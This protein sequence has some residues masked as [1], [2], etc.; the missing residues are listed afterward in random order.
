MNIVHLGLWQLDIEARSLSKGDSQAHLKPRTWDVLLHLVN[1]AGHLVSTEELLDQYWRGAIS[2]ETAV[3]KAISEIRHEIDDPA[4]NPQVIKTVP[5]RGY[6]LALPDEPS[7]PFV[8]GDALAVLPFVNITGDPADEYLCDGLSEE[9]LNAMVQTLDT[10][11]IARTSSFQF[12][13]LNT[14]VK[15]IASRLSANRILEG[16]LRRDGSVVRVTAQLIDGATGSHIWS[17][18]YDRES[19]NVF[20]LQESI[21]TAICAKISAHT[22]VHR[23]SAGLATPNM[24][25]YDLFLRATALGESGNPFEVRD[26]VTLFEQAVERDPAFAAAWLGLAN[27][28]IRLAEDR[29]AIMPASEVYPRAERALKRVLAL[30]PGNSRAI[31]LLGWIS[32]VLSYKWDAGM[33]LMERSLAATPNDAA[34]LFKYAYLRYCM[35]L[36]DGIPL[37]EEACKL[38]PL[39]PEIVYVLAVARLFAGAPNESIQTIGT[40]LENGR[41]DY[42]THFLVAL[43]NAFAGRY[44]V[45][46]AHYTRARKI[47]GND[48][49]AIRVLEYYVAAIRNLPSQ[50]RTTPA[51]LEEIEARSTDEFF[52]MIVT[53]GW[54]ANSAEKMWKHAL[55]QQQPGNLMYLFGDKPVQ[56]SDTFWH[57]VTEDLGIAP[58]LNETPRDYLRPAIERGALL[59]RRSNIDV[60]RLEEFA[61]TW[62]HCE[63]DDDEVVI[64][65]R[66]SDLWIIYPGSEESYWLVPVGPDR[67]EFHAFYRSVTFDTAGS[68]KTLCEEL[69]G[70]LTTRVLVQG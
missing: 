22:R 11:V 68:K 49:P 12:K 25:A 57:Q 54:L 23:S 19:V 48:F 51:I 15:E 41:R 44:E 52:P 61:G 67:F 59:A 10:P 16:S 66:G 24:P 20:E 30:D 50:E 21:A 43:I 35:R 27:A 65:R 63:D 1:H 3:R 33:Q 2:D 9:I 34:V 7:Q 28:L 32:V 40:L 45:A 14:D 26:A 47:V 39:D 62:I 17:E 53:M 29:I 36:P 58:F 56:L 18:V 42:S 64:E 70:A 5:K 37:I 6:L 8:A 31:G 69:N 4:G 46:A 38:N 60:Q 55:N 13:G